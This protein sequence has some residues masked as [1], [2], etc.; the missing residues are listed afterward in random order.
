MA[1][2]SNR[3]KALDGEEMLRQDRKLE[4]NV[5]TTLFLFSSLLVCS[6]GF[7]IASSLNVTLF[8]V[9]IDFGSLKI[10]LIG[11]EAGDSP[12]AIESLFFARNG[13]LICFLEGEI[14]EARL[15]VNN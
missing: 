8:F 13:L 14:R 2:E 11:V 1:P 6:V 4:V 12:E 7:F 9:F 10:Y 15:F 5:L 3:T